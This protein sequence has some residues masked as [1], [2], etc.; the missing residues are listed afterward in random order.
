VTH[1]PGTYY[2]PFS[3]SE[4]REGLADW[5]EI[6]PQPIQKAIEA[7]RVNFGDKAFAVGEIMRT[8]CYPA[9]HPVAE[10]TTEPA[11]F[12][13]YFYSLAQALAQDVRTTFLEMLSIALAQSALIASEP[14]EWAA[15]QIRVLISDKSAGISI[16]LKD[17]CDKQEYCPS[18]DAEELIFWRSWRA[19]RWL[20]MQPFANRPYD[21]AIAWERMDE[22]ET[23]HVLQV[24]ESRFNQQL[25]MELQKTIDQTHITRAKTE[26]QAG[27]PTQQKPQHSA[28]RSRRRRIVLT[29]AKKARKA[30]IAEALA[31]GLVGPKYG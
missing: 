15:S 7:L 6:T 13:S 28:Q 25:I 4:L 22:A 18:D 10:S 19:P 16:W 21:R 30:A 31:K 23:V 29:D 3:A 27:R 11:V 20:F 12:R 1:V 14:V 5:K 8:R 2:F 26:K 9:L 24:V 17:A